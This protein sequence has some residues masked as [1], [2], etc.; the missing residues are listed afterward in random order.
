[1]ARAGDLAPRRTLTG[2]QL[3]PLRARTA[4]ALAAGEISA[5]HAE[6][7]TGYVDKV[8]RLDD[9]APDGG[10]I[11][12]DLL[13]KAARHDHPKLVAQLGE[14]LL[15][16]LDPDGT[17]PKDVD[18][19]RERGYTLVKYADGS[20]TPRGRLTPEATAAWE[21]LLDPLA[22][23][24]PDAS[25]S[26]DPRSAAQRR[27]DAMLDVAKR[28]LRGQVASGGGTPL[29][30]LLRFPAGQFPASM[31]DPTHFAWDGPSAATD[32]AYRDVSRL[33][34]THLAELDGPHDVGIIGIGQTAHG[35]MISLNRLGSALCDTDLV[36][37]VVDHH[38]GVLA[39][40]RRRRLAS[41]TNAS[42]SP[43]ATADAASPAAPDQPPGPKPTT[44]S[45][46]SAAGPPT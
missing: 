14:R 29:T 26:A 31:V 1:V 10:E 41:K 42:R 15:A 30:V 32:T 6:V 24:V 5:A 20:S 7:I 38:G 25:G 17:A 44:S 21:A 13:L 27:H 18:L 19:D 36:A 16:R 4:A 46:G 40:G 12:E 23:P 45:P 9:A 11:A 43:P 34:G 37:T 2:D 8:E 33:A 3:P 39:F 28:L 35:A 22:A